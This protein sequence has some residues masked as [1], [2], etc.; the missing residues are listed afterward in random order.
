MREI[1]RTPEER[2]ADLEG[3][4][5]APHYHE[6]EGA[7]M[8]YLDEGP[9]G[10]PVIPM[11]HGMP[12]WSNLYRRMIPV[13]VEDGHRCIAPAAH[14]LGLEG[15]GAA[16]RRHRGHHNDGSVPRR[17]ARAGGPPLRDLAMR[18]IPDRG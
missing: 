3:Y 2:L 13:L 4:P 7:R 17:A 10:G 12:T 5:F 1:F 6:Y 15:R 16:L 11:A 18:R 9:R 8:H 14:L